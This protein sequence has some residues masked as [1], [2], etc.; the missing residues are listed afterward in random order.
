MQSPEGSRDSEHF[1][2]LAHVEVLPE[3]ESAAQR[4]LALGGVAMVLGAP[5]TGKSTFS[6]YLVY[7]TYLAGEPVALV[8]LDLGQSHLG[9]PA[10]LGLG[11]FPPRRPGDDALF[12]EGLYFIGQTSPVGAILEVTVG[13]RVLVDLAARQGVGRVVVN[14]SGLVQGYAARK[15]KLSQAE[16]LQ[17]SL[18]FALQREQELAFL[19][20]ALGDETPGVDMSSAEAPPP[21]GGGG[22]GEGE[23]PPPPFISSPKT[24]NPKPKTV[25][26]DTTAW[27]LVKLP[28]SARVVPRSP[29]ERRHYREQRFR[30]Y[31]H[32][33]RRLT[34][35]WRSLVWEGLPF[36]R[37]EPEKPQD[38]RPFGENLEGRGGSGEP[39]ESPRGASAAAGPQD[40]PYLDPL[41]SLAGGSDPQPFWPDLHLSLVGLLS[42]ARRTLALGLILPD[43]GAPDLVALWTPL[44]SAAA[45]QVRF[46]KVGQVKL[47][48]EGQELPYV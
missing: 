39:G 2:F 41:A 16:L 38:P 40:D 35:P 14:T 5:D 34:L 30:R 31:F 48:L 1:P 24:E 20:R 7:R 13:C 42:A 26:N 19:L 12:P 37:E 29:I 44:A 27:P 17:P 4:F 28:V 46:I 23:L 3:W 21:L 25:S 36:G 8:D 43:P 15:L 32:Q 10:T 18:I 9:P 45:T 47:N 33:A 6:R 11:L 22:G